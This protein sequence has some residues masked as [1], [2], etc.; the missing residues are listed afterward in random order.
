MEFL[1]LYANTLTNA[2]N[3]YTLRT[4]I[5]RVRIDNSFRILS[6]ANAFLCRCN[7]MLLAKCLDKSRENVGNIFAIEFYV[8]F[9]M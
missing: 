7:E 1:H 6:N 4:E 3:L 5:L 8:T 9:E 2:T